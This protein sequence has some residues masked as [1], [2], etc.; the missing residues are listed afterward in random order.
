MNAALAVSQTK[1]SRSKQKRR[2]RKLT[3]INVPKLQKQE[4]LETLGWS[5][6]P[7]TLYKAIENDLELFMKEH[8]ENHSTIDGNVRARRNRIQY[9]VNNYKNGICSLDTALLALS[10]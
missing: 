10:N 5:G 6:I 1:Y 4:L 2:S 3:S 7:L 9:W 8:L